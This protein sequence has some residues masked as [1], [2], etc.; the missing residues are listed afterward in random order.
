MYNYSVSWRWLLV[1]VV[2]LKFAEW[3]ELR[4]KSYQ[5]LHVIA[6]VTSFVISEVT[7]NYMGLYGL[8]ALAI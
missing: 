7:C 6:C 2:S 1:L 8:F 3:Y 5:N 4:L